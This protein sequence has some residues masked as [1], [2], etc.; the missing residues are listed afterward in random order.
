M[1]QAV[2]TWF[3]EMNDIHDTGSG[4]SETSYYPPLI[5]LFNTLRASLRPAVFA[6]STPRNTCSGIPG[7]AARSP[8]GHWRHEH[9]QAQFI[10]ELVNR[11]HRYSPAFRRGLSENMVL[12]QKAD[13]E[14]DTISEMQAARAV[15]RSREFV[16][17]IR[18]EESKTL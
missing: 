5:T 4:T 17:A 15:R 2:E 7:I 6:V 14:T 8:R 1:R 16:E 12:R 10:G 13:Y 3:H 18:L 11:R 9:I